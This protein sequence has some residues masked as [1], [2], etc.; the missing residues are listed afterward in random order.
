V[1]ERYVV[2][3]QNN[4]NHWLIF[5]VERA[6]VTPWGKL[7]AAVVKDRNLAERIARLLNASDAAANE[8]QA[9]R[10]GQL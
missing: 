8:R 5:D 10:G 1:S 9:A 2:D 3:G 6:D 7:A 4:L